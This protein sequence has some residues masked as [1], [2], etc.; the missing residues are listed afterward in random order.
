MFC[1]AVSVFLYADDAADPL[2][3]KATSGDMKAAFELANEY[4]QGTAT[5]K[6]NPVL[7]V[8]WFQKAADTY[9][10]AMFNYGICLEQGLGITRDPVAA[11][12]CY[13]KAA[14]KNCIPAQY[15]YAL[16]LIK[17]IAF[18]TEDELK[19]YE[20]KKMPE[21]DPVKGFALLKRL[22]DKHYVPAMVEYA[23]ELMSKGSG[24]SAANGRVVFELM[25]T[26][27][28]MPD[29][30]ARAW[31]I[32]GDCYFSGIGTLPDGKKMVEMLE[33]AVERGSV[34]ALS[35]LG[36]CY[37][38]GIN[39]KADPR[40]ALHYYERAAQA[41][42]PAAM[43]KYADLILAGEVE[44]QGLDDAI[45]W[46]E[47][48]ANAGYPEAIYRLG[49]YSAIG[50]GLA[51][52]PTVA[53][54]F[55]YDAAKLGHGHAQFELGCIYLQEKGPA[56]KDE[57]TAFYW[58]EKAASQSDPGAQR[59]L[60]L[61]Y[62]N[63]TGCKVDREQSARWLTEAAKNGDREAAKILQSGKIPPTTGQ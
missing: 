3:D 57:K 46:V 10:E 35:R 13:K 53:Y 25:S 19:K 4:F 50:L 28:K 39:V 9:P 30:P 7:A 32:L 31:R 18:K 62:A 49:T 16:F 56:V 58:F 45:P 40:L 41:G 34:E 44:G 15:N 11:V 24:I 51:K 6:A 29:A 5:R 61:C 63:G 2:R 55:Y 54:K 47:K 14:D 26:A 37:E 27:I 8:Y 42:L 1:V 60:G 33:K 48:S 36:Y 43:L 20:G 59:M 21:S 12:E 52:N 38:F 22:S 17:G 23:A